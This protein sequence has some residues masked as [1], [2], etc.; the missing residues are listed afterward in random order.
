VEPA[1]WTPGSANLTDPIFGF[2]Q[3]FVSTYDFFGGGGSDN[4]QEAWVTA[5]EQFLNQTG[6]P[7]GPFLLFAQF[8]TNSYAAPPLGNQPFG[9]APAF[10]CCEPINTNDDRMIYATLAN[11]SSGNKAARVWAGQNTGVNVKD[12]DDKDLENVPGVATYDINFG[13]PFSGPSVVNQQIIASADAGVAFGSAAIQ[14]GN[15]HGGAI[16][17]SIFGSDAGLYPS[18]A[19]SFVNPGRSQLAKSIMV[20]G[21]GQDPLDEF[22]VRFGDYSSS[23]AVG[24]TLYLESELVQYPNCSSGAYLADPTCGGTRGPNTNWGTSI[25]VVKDHSAAE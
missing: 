5:G 7:N 14:L 8:H 16:S 18:S 25:T 19:F 1:K 15:V 4:R 2:D 6:F 21:P 12:T 22:A 24:N 10:G 20:S 17:F 3:Y 11:P 23:V 13:F 9:N